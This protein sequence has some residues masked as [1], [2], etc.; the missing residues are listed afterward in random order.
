[1]L[2]NVCLCFCVPD[3]GSSPI[4][5]WSQRSHIW[6]K[7]RG[8][9]DDFDKWVANGSDPTD[10]VH[11]KIVPNGAIYSLG[12]DPVK[13]DLYWNDKAKHSIYR[14]PR[15]ASFKAGDNG[16]GVKTLF[17]AGAESEIDGIAVDWMTK[18]VYF[19]D[20]KKRWIGVVAS[21]K[22]AANM[23]RILFHTDLGDPKGITLDPYE[24]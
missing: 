2:V 16:D 6:S 19:T 7:L 9:R 15:T 12:Y 20:Y 17:A 14:Q 23:Y 5:V 21:G 8:I 22:H 1:M 4:V 3:S 13:D 10:T 24:G 18:M 11:S